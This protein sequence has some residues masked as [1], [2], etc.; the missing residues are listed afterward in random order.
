MAKND[1]LLLDGILDDRVANRVPSDRRDEAFEYLAIE[2]LLK[3][4]DFSSEELQ[5]GIIDGE[6]DG[7]IDGFYLIVN[8]HL[9]LDPESFQWP[10]ANAEL[11][12]V[13]VSCK[14]H[15]TF[16]QATLDGLIATLAELL[17]FAIEEE[18]LSGSYSPR[19]L[20]M[21]RNLIFAY[22]KLSPKLS[23]FAVSAFYASRGD[24]QIVGSEVH[25]RGEQIKAI[26]GESFGWSVGAF[27]FIGAT[28][29]VEL[30][31]KIPSFT[32]D[33]PFVE[34]LA[35]G[36]RY[37]L[38]ARLTDYYR[39]VSED[40]RL[41]RYL[42]ESNV[43][44]FMGMNRVNED[45]QATLRDAT[46][47]DFWLLNNGV[48]VLATSAAITGKSIRISDIQ[49]VNG[50]QTTESIF[51]YLNSGSTQADQRCVLVK[52]I[53]TNNA[54]VRDAIIRATNNQ[55]NVELSELHATDKIQRDI[56]DTLLRRG[57]HYERRKNYYANQGISNI[58]I[59]SPLYLAA[60]Y[61]AL[62][63]KAPSQATKL[64]S[65]FMRASESYRRVFDDSAPLEV[66]T[67]ISQ[68][69]KRVDS[70]LEEL[71][72][73]SGNSDSFLKKWRYILALLVC[74]DHFRKFSFS[75]S[76]LSTFD[77]STVT[78]RV[79]KKLWHEIGAVIADPGETK[80]RRLA[81]SGTRAIFDSF[82]DKRGIKDAKVVVSQMTSFD[83]R[84]KPSIRVTDEFVEE[85]RA[86][87]PAQ[88]WKPGMHI[89]VSSQLK[90]GV[91]QFFVA[92][93]RLIEEGVVN[94]QKD[95][96]VYD[97]DGNVLTFDRERVDAN[98]MEL[99]RLEDD[100]GRKNETTG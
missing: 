63:R 76:E 37:V 57:L 7:G 15:D 47:P 61:I 65:R 77:A 93:D 20:E 42:F 91:K 41:R 43:R 39:F 62:V 68:V 1:K 36:E 96:V 35:A 88:P 94:F 70:C 66:W 60:G 53:V 69:L 5:S 83:R 40:G 92:V 10:R 24:T 56:E 82:A 31:R 50:L 30:H 17:D 75:S 29:L 32:L 51:R 28:E 12:L 18:Q 79:I 84:P 64:R 90:C 74:A 95:G 13:L 85:V 3:E 81:A 46:S 19:L 98:T 9:V 34:A 38:L 100:G 21:R 58:S 4:Y 8:G 25:S 78:L 86:V 14:H 48:T 52:V 55:T 73:K 45:I 54:V 27:S 33:L 44:D 26:I 59:V 89:E 16:K 22:R 99:Y 11:K 6:R 87:L 67:V 80:G 2:Q 97:A 71:R 23:A 49:I 72:P